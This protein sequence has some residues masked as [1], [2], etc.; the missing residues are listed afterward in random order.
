VVCNFLNGQLVSE[1]PRVGGLNVLYFISSLPKQ[2]SVYAWQW[3][4][5][6]Y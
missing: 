3:W 2:C 1:T 4:T 5:R 6:E